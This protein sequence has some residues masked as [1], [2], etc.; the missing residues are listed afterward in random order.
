MGKLNYVVLD[1]TTRHFKRRDRHIA[2]IIRTGKAIN[3]SSVH[4]ALHFIEFIDKLFEGKSI[5]L[6]KGLGTVYIFEQLDFDF[7][8]FEKMSKKLLV[9]SHIFIDA[10]SVDVLNSQ[11][12]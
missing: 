3:I 12:F 7:E 1:D 2:I 5:S 10:F 4:L 8:V 6:S 9:S 11:L